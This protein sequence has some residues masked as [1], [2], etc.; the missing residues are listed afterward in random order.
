MCK[1]KLTVEQQIEHLEEKGITFD[2][3]SKED[4]KDYLC[5]NSY[6]FKLASYRK[7]F[8]KH[9]YGEDKDK[10]IKLDFA[11]LVDLAVIDMRLRY[12]L[13]QMSMDIEHYIKVELLS[14]IGKNLLE[15]GY[16]ICD[17]FRNSLPEEQ[18]KRLD[19]EIDKCNDSDYTRDLLSHYDNKHIPVWILLE[20]IPFGRLISFYKFCADRF[21]DKKMQKNFF[22][23]LPCKQV[24]NAAAHSSCMLNNLLPDTAVRKPSNA[25]SRALSQVSNLSETTRKRKMMNLRIQ[26]IVTLLYVHKEFVTSRGVHKRAA[27]MLS[28]LAVRM[29]KN[30]DY[31]EDNSCVKTSLCFLSSVIDKWFEIEENSLTT[32]ID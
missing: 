7:N 9:N 16:S 15:D 23:L 4:A 17:D 2:L 21:N 28:D 13:V 14:I 10:Y 6:Y 20:V 18:L 30:I 25:V 11:Q 27:T 29:N 5:N 24:R 1:P 31:Y 19:T 8:P 3:Y 32:Q 12:I 26:Q 22:L